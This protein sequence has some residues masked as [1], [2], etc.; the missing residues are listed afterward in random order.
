MQGTIASWVLGSEIRTQKPRYCSFQ[1]KLKEVSPRHKNGAQ[2]QKVRLSLKGL[3]LLGEKQECYLC[4][5]QPL[6]PFY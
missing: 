2:A 6:S 5:M 1:P 4:A 3:G